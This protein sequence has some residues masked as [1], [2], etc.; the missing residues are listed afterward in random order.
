TPNASSSS[1]SSSSNHPA[2]ED[3]VELSLAG[4]IAL[5]VGDGKLTSAQ[6]QQ[7]DSQL[8]GINQQIQSGGTGIGQSQ[9][10]LSEQIYGDGHNGAS[11]PANLNVTTADERDF[12]QAG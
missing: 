7:L 12:L 5:G 10:Q 1:S 4:R 8:Q 9:S 2:L 3:A 11:I 6:G